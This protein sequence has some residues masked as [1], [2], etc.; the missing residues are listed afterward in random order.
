MTLEFLKTEAASGMILAVAALSAIILANSPWSSAYFNFIDAALTIQVGAFR[1]THSYQDWI[2]EGLMAIFFL[3]VGLEIK[4]EILRGE[5]ANPRRLLL[6][7]AAALGGMAAPALVYLAVNLGRGGAPAGWPVP[8]ATDIAFALAAL[9]V[10]GPR[11]PPS[12][13]AFLLTLAIV[14]DLGAVIAIGV[15]FTDHVE[16][17]AVGGAASALALMVLLSRWKAAPYLLYALGFLLV[18]AF[19]LESGISTSL[20]GVAA[21]AA[22]PISAQKPGHKGLV[23]EMMHSLHPYVAYLILPLFAFAAAGFTFEG[24]GPLA[25]PVG[26]GVAAGLLI[27]KPLG[28]LGATGLII[29]LKLSRRPT[30]ARWSELAG[31]SILCGIG[32]TMSLFIGQLAFTGPGQGQ[33]K[34][35]VVLG[36]V[37]SVLLGAA[38]LAWAQ[39]RRDREAAADS[40]LAPVR[41]PR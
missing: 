7:V 5:L 37:A 41:R 40:A 16:W 3:V 18:W 23:E 34:V 32:F 6:P 15:L 31:V 11:L 24:A 17:T 33:V 26:L 38:L 4:Y 39:A 27:G 12:L 28:I 30:G 2:K 22:V 9:A 20:A 14:D 1:Q 13:R 35:G 29:G 36:S 8:M 10:A 19:T 25:G 21:A